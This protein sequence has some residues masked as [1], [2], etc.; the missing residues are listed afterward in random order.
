MS[1]ILQFM[2]V[3]V[4]YV[5]FTAAF[6]A[7]TI[8]LLS[9]IDD[10]PNNKKIMVSLLWGIFWP[11]IWIKSRFTGTDIVRAGQHDPKARSCTGSSEFDTID[12]AKRR[13]S[14]IREAK[15]FLA[16]RIF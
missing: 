2:G 3:W 14:T 7:I 5:A 8:W 12:R 11:L 10:V 9:I 13:F 1:S 15:D 6:I 16:G 4:G